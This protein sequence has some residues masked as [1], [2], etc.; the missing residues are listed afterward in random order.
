VE[1]MSVLRFS[2]FVLL[3][4][5]GFVRAFVLFLFS[6]MPLCRKAA[7]DGKEVVTG[8]G[9]TTGNEVLTYVHRGL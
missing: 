5:F 4:A 6:L 2:P 3:T 1:G 9:C 8:R 7:K